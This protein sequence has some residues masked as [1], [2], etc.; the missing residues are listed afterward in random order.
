MRAAPD[1][2]TLSCRLDGVGPFRVLTIHLGKITDRYLVW[3]FE[4]GLGYG[5]GRAVALF[6]LSRDF[7]LRYNVFLG[8]LPFADTC[9]CS[10]FCVR[11]VCKHLIA[12]REV[13]L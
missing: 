13:Q 4:P 10:G 6:K 7:G 2:S 3:A 1:Y 12:I 8:V 5:E 9:D 11:G